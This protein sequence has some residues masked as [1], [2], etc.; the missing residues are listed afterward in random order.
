[1]DDLLLRGIELFNEREFFECH[2]VLEAA[3]TPERG[4]RRLFLQAL[5]HVAVGFYHS[6][7][8]NSVGASRQ[9]RKALRKLSEFLPSREGVDTERLFRE[10]QAVLERIES[11]A[12]V[13]AYP[14]IRESN[15]DSKTVKRRKKKNA[16]A[17]PGAGP[18]P[19]KSGSR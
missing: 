3:W 4:P 11:G 2:E 16:P 19:A 5:I 6:E 8:G 10:A 14:R 15:D 1:M 9:L 12:P 18:R 13:R 17:G 7:R